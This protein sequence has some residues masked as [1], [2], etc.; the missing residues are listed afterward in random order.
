MCVECVKVAFDEWVQMQFSM[1]PKMHLLLAHV[2]DL[3]KHR[4]GVVRIV[5]RRI[6]RVHQAQHKYNL[7][8]SSFV[9]TVLRNDVKQKIQCVRNNVEIKEVTKKL[10]LIKKE[11]NKEK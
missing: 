3:L 9:N 2:A 4:E 5:E 10:W 1:T 8:A 7:I 11:R 6:E